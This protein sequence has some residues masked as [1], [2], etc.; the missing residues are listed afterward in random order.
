ML[1]LSWWACAQ[2]SITLD[3]PENGLFSI[4]PVPMRQSLIHICGQFQNQILRRLIRKSWPILIILYLLIG[5]AFWNNL[6]WLVTNLVFVLSVVEHGHVVE[7][8]GCELLQHRPDHVD[9]AVDLFLHVDLL[10]ENWIINQ[11]MNLIALL[12][13]LNF[14][15]WQSWMWSNL[16]IKLIKCFWIFKL[17]YS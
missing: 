2:K 12:F 3:E 1:C 17:S 13:Q 8:L 9:K 16:F 7:G 11:L 10:L 14:S 5:R 6:C 15:K 4:G